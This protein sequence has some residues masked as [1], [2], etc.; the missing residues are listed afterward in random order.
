MANGI[1][2]NSKHE[3]LPAYVDQQTLELLDA[4][5]ECGQLREILRLAKLGLWAETNSGAIR[6][7]L[8]LTLGE[9]SVAMITRFENALAGAPKAKLS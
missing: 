4:I 7:S 5:A 3:K 6:D 9:L 8:H 2:R 1:A